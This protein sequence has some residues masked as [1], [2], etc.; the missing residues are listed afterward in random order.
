VQLQVKAPAWLKRRQ[1]A[2]VKNIIADESSALRALNYELRDGNL[3]AYH[4]GK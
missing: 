4:A 2:L 1:A 3:G